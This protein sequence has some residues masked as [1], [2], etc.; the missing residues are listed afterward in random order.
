ML[1]HM[2]LQP[3]P[4]RKMRNG[5]KTIELR[6]NDAKRQKIQVGDQIEFLNL[7]DRIQKIRV[8]VVALHHFNSFEELYRGLPLSA[9]GYGPGEQADPGDMERY[10]S[11]EE[12]RRYGVVG[13]EVEL[14][15]WRDT[16][17]TRISR[18]LSFVL[19]HRPEAAGITLDKHGWASVDEL[20]RG[21]SEKW[22][23]NMEMLEEIVATDE[24]RRYSFSE[25]KTRIRANQ[26]HSIPVD[27]EL[28]EKTPPVQLW[29]GTGRKY[30]ES[31][32]RE[33]L[34]SKSRLY[35]HLS[36]DYETAVAVG[37]RHGD[38]V[39]YQVLAGQM[40][41]DGYVF[42]Q[43]VNQVWLTKYV[44]AEYLKRCGGAEV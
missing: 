2:K 1:H 7:G 5:T 12:Q 30:V 11:R 33:G 6:L 24:K 23:L 17:L 27:V 25:D 15:Q 8:C 18:Y 36:S 41:R 39:V 40:H 29:H 3:E 38:P 20:L 9:C 14:L 28:E 13:I 19:R 10:Y 32:E 44:P 16:L 21:V 22:P 42:Y 43:S 4:F 35:V 37:R 26:G 34:V 31:I